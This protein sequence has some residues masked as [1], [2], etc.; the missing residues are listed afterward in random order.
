M[1]QSI[2]PPI[3][4]AS[5]S[6]RRA[7]L[8]GALGLPFNAVPSDFDESSVHESAPDKL[9]EQLALHKASTVAQQLQQRSCSGAFLVIG[10]DTIVVLADEILGKPRDSADATAILARLQGH[11]HTV[12]TGL[13]LIHQPADGGQPG[14]RTSVQHRRTRVTMEALDDDQIRRYVATGE[15]LDKAGAYAIQG[16]GATLITE[17]HGDYSNVVGL[18]LNLLA[19]MLADF[20][21]VVPLGG[22]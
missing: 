10:A 15:P 5:S 4:L 22:R 7:E 11:T 14:L 2:I 20:G 3:F 21:F 6:P 1:S 12:F 16:I 17:I 9:V 13:C 19:I 18:P 8:L